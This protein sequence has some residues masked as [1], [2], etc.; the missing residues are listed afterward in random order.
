MMKII[1]DSEFEAEV[2]QHPG[3]V[4]VDF[5]ADWCGPCRALSPILESLAVQYGKTDGNGKGVKFVKVDVDK[6]LDLAAFFQVNSI[7]TLILFEDG[8]PVQ[9]SM[10][11]QSEDALKKILGFVPER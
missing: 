5:S 3:K 6:S 2:L 4:L 1:R 8:K 11:L 10:G 7:P 9:R